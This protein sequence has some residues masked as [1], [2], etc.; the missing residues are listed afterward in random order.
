MDPYRPTHLSRQMCVSHHHPRR[1]FQWYLPSVANRRR[2]FFYCC[3][4]LSPLPLA[5]NKHFERRSVC[6][7]VADVHKYWADN[8]VACADL[9]WGSEQGDTG[10]QWVVQPS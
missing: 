1:S 3:F 2:T 6:Q 10:C 8:H 7:P 9:H 5:S 4:N